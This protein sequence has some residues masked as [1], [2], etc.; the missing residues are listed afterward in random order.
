[1]RI[2]VDKSMLANLDGDTE[3]AFKAALE[4][5]KASGVTIIDIEMPNSP[6]STARSDFRSRSTKPMT[7]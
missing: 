6:S 7:T 2:G 5:L 1:M 4:K 3:A